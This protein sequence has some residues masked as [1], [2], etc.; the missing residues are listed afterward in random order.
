[1]RKIDEANLP[2][3]LTPNELTREVLRKSALGE[4]VYRAEDAEQL[5]RKLELD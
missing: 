4:E 3:E 2:L 1:M 5:F